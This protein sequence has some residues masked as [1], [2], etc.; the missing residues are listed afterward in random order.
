MNKVG[1]ERRTKAFA[2][3]V[4]QFDLACRSI[5]TLAKGDDLC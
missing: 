5:A 2:L 4:I 1:L 3:R